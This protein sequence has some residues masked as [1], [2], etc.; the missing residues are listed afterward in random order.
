MHRHRFPVRRIIE[1]LLLRV[2]PVAVLL[3]FRMQI[4]GGQTAPAPNEP[5]STASELGAYEPDKGFVV[6]RTST[7]E[8]IL[9]AWTYVRYLNQKAGLDQTFTDS[10]GRTSTLQLRQDMQLNKLSLYTKGWIYDPRLNYFLYVWTS[11]TSMGLGA[12]VVVAGNLSYGF[13]PRFKLN[14]GIGSLPTTRTTQGTFPYLLKVDHRTIADEY[15]RGSYT[16][17]IW[18]DGTAAEG[19]KYKLMIGNNLS[20]LGVDASQLD[21]LFNTVSGALWWMPTTKEFGPRDGYGDFEAHDRVATLFGAHYTRSREDSQ[22]QPNTED[23]EN[24]QIRLSDGTAIFDP[25]AFGPGTQI[26]RASYRMLALDSGL[27]YRG[28][29][30]E[31]EYFARRVDDFAAQGPLPVEKLVDHGFQLQGSAMV[32]PRKLQAYVSGSRIFGEYGDPWDLSAGLNWFPT[33]NRN[34]R[35]NGQALYLSRSPVGYAS[36]PFPLGGNGFVYTLDTEVYF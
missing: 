36:V 32:R 19:L 15:F 27:K 30:L 11:N 24:T 14:A 31:G 4:L 3:L 18:A 2:L 28:F 33:G 5:V 6:A 21:N 12:Q 20:Y 1:G 26:D 29:S 35:I 10:F 17:G 9:S 13:S 16:A 23:P 25:D 8:L 34:L 22:S 7:G